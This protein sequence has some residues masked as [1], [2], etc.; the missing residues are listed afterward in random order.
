[1]RQKERTT[2]TVIRTDSVRDRDICYRYELIMKEGEGVANWRIPLY[3][4]RVYMTDQHGVTTMG[5]VKD[6]FADA[7]KAIIFYE[8]I[9]RNLATPIDLVYILEDDLC[10]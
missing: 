10:P 6:I 5:D 4:V 3:T 7:G 8:K 2:D 9:V 1:M